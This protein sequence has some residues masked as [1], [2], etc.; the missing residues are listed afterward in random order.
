MGSSIESSTAISESRQTDETAVVSSPSTSETSTGITI[1]DGNTAVNY[2]KE[3]LAYNE[4]SSYAFMGEDSDEKGNYYQIRLVSTSIK[5]MV[6]LGLW[7]SI[8]YTL[9]VS[10]ASILKIKA[11]LF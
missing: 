4:D 2:L 11:F 10:I 1:T 5:I 3:K 8:K 6:V 9:M 7:V